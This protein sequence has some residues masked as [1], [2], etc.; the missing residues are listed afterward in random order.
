MLPKKPMDPLTLRQ[1]KS[2]KR[3]SKCQIC[4]KPF[5][6]QNPKVRDHCH[7]TGKYRG[8]ADSNCIVRYRVPSYI[9][10][11]FHNLSGYDADLFI[12]ELGKESKDI[13]VIAK[14]REDYITFWVNVTVDKYSNKNGDEKDKFIELRFIDSFKFMASS[15][16]SL[17]NNFFRGGRKLVGFEDYSEEQYELLTRKGVYPYEYMSC[18]DKFTETQLPPIEAFCSSLSM[19]NVSDDNYQHAQKVWS[20]FSIHNLGEYYDLY[21]CTNVILLANVF[22]AF[23]DTCLEHYSLDP[24]HSYTS[25]GLAWKACLKKTGVKLELLTDPDMLLMFEHGIRGGITQVVHHYT[26]VNNPYMGPACPGSHSDLM[27]DKFNPDENT[28]YLQYL[29]AN[30]LYG[31]AMSQ[32]LPTGRFR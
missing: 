11:V 15:L 6:G 19:S 14:N 23:R 2:Y 10:V 4:Y 17:T 31:L 5:K 24:A 20:T 8:S 13:G 29:N 27:G 18:W 21:L 16:D 9:P 32:S 7:Y 12:K 1:W 28:C 22:E 25:P 3:V 30:N 26:K